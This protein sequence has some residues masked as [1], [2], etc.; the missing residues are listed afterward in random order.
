MKL[1]GNKLRLFFF[2]LCRKNARLP[3]T[4]ADNNNK[5]H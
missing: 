1:A 5:T 3:R 4:F 2:V